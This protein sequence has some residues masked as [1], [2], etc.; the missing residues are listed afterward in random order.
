MKFWGDGSRGL[1][2]TAK[3]EFLKTSLVQK[4]DFIKAQ[5]QDHGQKK[6]HWACEEWLIIYSGARSGKVKR[7]VS[8]ESF[9]C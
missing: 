2:L 5:G 6:L 7:E 4:D 9:I 1:E 8:K 3:K